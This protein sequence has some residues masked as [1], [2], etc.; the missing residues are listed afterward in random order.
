MCTYN[1]VFFSHNEVLVHAARMNRENMLSEVIQTQK[2]KYLRFH[3]Y[4]VPE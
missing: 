2:D 3:L 4:E 1:E